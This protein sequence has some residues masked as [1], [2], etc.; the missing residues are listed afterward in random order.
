MSRKK[1]DYIDNALKDKDFLLHIYVLEK[2]KK[3]QSNVEAKHLRE[4]IHREYFL[5]DADIN[6]ILLSRI[7]RVSP[8][9]DGSHLLSFDIKKES[10][11]L[12]LNKDT[13]DEEIDQA[14]S[15]FRRMRRN[16]M[17]K[18]AFKPKPPV[19]GDLIYAYSR[20][21]A[22]GLTGKEIFNNLESGK[23][24]LYSKENPG[25]IDAD[26]LARYYRKYKPSDT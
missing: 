5:N 3:E 11:T 14:L 4:K 26:S 21:V 17:G 19:Y 8:Y 16:I 1:N 15:D 10:W 12:K 24:D 22:E 6:G 2:L 23:L 20:A 9:P 7:L 25:F 18:N 13:T